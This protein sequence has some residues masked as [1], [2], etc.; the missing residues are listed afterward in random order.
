MTEYLEYGKTTMILQADNLGGRVDVLN[1][2]RS[3]KPR[4]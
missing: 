1:F 4:I 2:L 3:Q